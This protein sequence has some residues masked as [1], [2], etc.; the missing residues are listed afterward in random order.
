MIKYVFITI[1]LF[2]TGVRELAAQNSLGLPH[3]INYN[4]STYKGGRQNWSIAQDKDGILYFG[5]NE[6][7]LTFDG[8]YWQLYPLPNATVVRSVCIAANGTIYVGGQD[9]I[10]YFIPNELGILTYHSLLPLVPETERSLSDVW[11]IEM[12]GENVFFR[13]T[14]RIVHYVNGKISIDKTPTTWHFLGR[15][16]EKIY[17]Q[18]G[19]DGLFV[20]ENQVW[21]PLANHPA[22]QEHTISSILPHGK[23]TLLVTTL[24]AGLFFLVN[25]RFIPFKTEIDPQLYLHRVY[26]S[27][28]LGKGRLALGTTASGLYITDHYGKVSRKFTYEQGLQN[29]YIRDIFLDRDN[30]LWL[31]LDYGIDYISLNSAIH[32]I[33]PDKENP[34][35][36]YGVRIFN[37]NLYIG[38]SNGLY[39]T[40]VLTDENGQIRQPDSRFRKVTGSDGQVWGLGEINGRLLMSHEDG[41]FEVTGNSLIPVYKGIGTWQFRGTSRI[42]PVKDLIS[43]TYNGLSLTSFEGGRFGYEGHIG[44][45]SESLRFIHYDE[46]G[47]SVWASHPNR[48]IFRFF[49]SED[50]RQVTRVQDYSTGKDLPSVLHN[51]LFYVR[52]TILVTHPEGVFEYD[53]S[54]DSFRPAPLYDALKGQAI[55]FMTE[56]PDGNVWFITHKKPGV[57]NF[58]RAG[59]DPSVIYFPELNAKVLGG[60]ES[61]YIYNDENIFFGAEKGVIVL[62]YRFYQEKDSKPNVLLRSV[63][64]IDHQR[65][66]KALFGG[67]ADENTNKAEVKYTFNSFQFTFTSPLYDQQDNILFSYMLEGTD[68]TWSPWNNRS[69]KEYTN[70]P[71]GNYRFKVKSRN[72]IGNESDIVMYSFTVHPPWFATKFS[73]FVYFLLSLLALYYL[74]LL[75]NRKLKQKHDRELHLQQLELQ[76]KE[77]EVM[78]LRNDR[79]EAD[80][81]FK[82]KELANMTMHLVQR[83]EI[84]SKIKEN[85]IDILKK[86]EQSSTKFNFRQLMR[87]IKDAER[88]NED[89]EQF[90]RNFN[91]AHEGFFLVLKAEHPDLTAH[92]LRL[93]ALL[94]M[95]LLSKEIAQIM[96][97][98]VKAVE[99]S[100]YRLRKKLRLDPEVNLHEYLSRYT[101]NALQKVNPALANPLNSLQ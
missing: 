55:Q 81:N 11:D 17:A 62:N 73:Y 65:Q 82:D 15:A 56:G 37:R 40:P 51:Y 19:S 99:I 80:I 63:R 61:I 97:V 78:Q 28:D 90:N 39:S 27:K 31:A 33:Y 59:Q 14:T 92:E 42:Q 36:S 24:K 26:C 29:N 71:A 64:A 5:N 75:Q 45:S 7:L 4:N 1:S 96:H 100:R 47:R 68:K 44:N 52:N 49:L 94:R 67:Y 98:S 89:W 35:S 86:Q 101:Q 21:K 87:L 13:T 50:L 58:N 83:G 6:G 12:L 41:A 79:L 23:D 9:E 53:R 18:N 66:E 22:L 95:N 2:F 54:S 30:N 10:G 88:T 32:Y 85:V 84:L 70:L 8:R 3:I 93:C 60:F 16:G 74:L 57:L 76:K 46:P 72:G 34:V 69:E 91:N 77:K 25:D 48:G 43:G 38:T 20:Y